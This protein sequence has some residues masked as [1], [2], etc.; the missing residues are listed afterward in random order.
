MTTRVTEPWSE[1]WDTRDSLLCILAGAR[2]R[3]YS[4][5]ADLLSASALR[6]GDEVMAMIDRD[7]ERRMTI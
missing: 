4:D 7:T 6:L 1:A 5:A 3:G 2:E